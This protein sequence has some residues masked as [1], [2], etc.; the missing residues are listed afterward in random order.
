MWDLW[1][2]AGVVR[3]C[4]PEAPSTLLASL[5]S[6]QDEHPVSPCMSPVRPLCTVVSC[7]SCATRGQH[8]PCMSSPRHLC[9][10]PLPAGSLGRAGPFPMAAAK[11]FCF[12]LVAASWGNGEPRA[13]VHVCPSVR[14]HMQGGDASAVGHQHVPATPLRRCPH[15]RAHSRLAPD[16]CEHQRVPAPQRGHSEALPSPLSSEPSSAPP[17]APL[18]SPGRPR[19]INSARKSL[20]RLFSPPSLER[21]QLSALGAAFSTFP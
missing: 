4:H 1:E 5:C 19:S 15:G 12:V 20:P 10:L 7:R 9:H 14:G 3:P 6:V 13:R 11:T 2:V 16:K 21:P 8:R 17:P 18:H